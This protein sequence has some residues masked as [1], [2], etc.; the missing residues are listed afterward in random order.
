M[1]SGDPFLFPDGKR[2]LFAGK[3]AATDA[4]QIYEVALSGGAPKWRT[5]FPG[6]AMNPTLLA[7]GEIVFSGPVPAPEHIWDSNEP[8]ALYA[9]SI[10]GPPRRLTFGMRAA[11]EPTVLS[12]GR[13]LFVSG[14]PGTARGEPPNLGLYTINND[15]TEF[16]AFA[17]DHDGKPLIRRPRELPAGR[18]AFLASAADQA[19]VFAAAEVIRT[20]RPFASRASLFPFQT[21]WCSSLEP[22]SKNRLVLCMYPE[23]IAAP[24]AP[25]SSA[26]YRIEPEAALLGEALLSDRRWRYIEA[27]PLAPR[28]PPL[29]H[30]SVMAPEKK[31]GTLLCLD[32]NFTRF[33]QSP[34]KAGERAARVR[35][36]AADICPGQDRLLGEIALQADGSFMAEVPADVPLGFETLTADG[37]TLAKVAPTIWVRPGENRSCLGC[38]EPSN[39][40]PRNLRPLAVTAPPAILS[41]PSQSTPGSP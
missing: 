22:D 2:L 17:L 21:G 38:H 4:W 18:I 8:A 33:S 41:K 27:L 32:A 20:A 16:T 6:G 25:S 19:Q 14:H 40:S 10:G 12:D 7:N 34:S 30:I 37:R 23:R 26:V 28:C 24:S 11:L 31:T 9:Q 36:T 35:I 5:A 13:I 15:G 3:R 29:G 39:R 1:A